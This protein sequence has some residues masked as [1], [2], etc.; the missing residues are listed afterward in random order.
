MA[1][2]L[3]GFRTARL[4]LRLRRARIQSERTARGGCG[5]R[6]AKSSGARAVRFLRRS[7]RNVLP[8]RR[9]PPGRFSGRPS[10]MG[11]IISTSTAENGATGESDHAGPLGGSTRSNTSTR[12][13]AASIFWPTDARR[14]EDP[15]QAHL[16][17]VGLRRQGTAAAHAREC[18]PF[19]EF[20]PGRNVL[21]RQ[22]FP[23]RS[24]GSVVIAP[25]QR[26]LGSARA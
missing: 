19:R 26:R 12:R 5:N 22:L 1:P 20:L 25:H 10:A 13:T 24:A 15:Y 21:R 2:A 9:R 17:S 8:L 11:G 7:G 6:R 14:S 18:E 23:S 3:S 16:Y 4:S